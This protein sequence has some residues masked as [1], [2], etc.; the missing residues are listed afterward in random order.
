MSELHFSTTPLTLHSTTPVHT[1]RSRRPPP[2]T[3]PSLGL[4]AELDALVMSAFTRCV[5][6]VGGGVN[7]LELPKLLYQ[8]QEG[9]GLEKVP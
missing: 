6:G 4:Q 7:F 9:H 1:T 5:M 3:P 8:A 2:P